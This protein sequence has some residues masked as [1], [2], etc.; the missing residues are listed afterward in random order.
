MIG[1]PRRLPPPTA[2]AVKTTLAIVLAAALAAGCASSGSSNASRDPNAPKRGSRNS[3]TCPARI[4]S[5]FLTHGTV[6]RAC[7]VDTPAHQQPTSVRPDIQP[8]RND[9]C[10]SAEFEFVVGTDGVPEG[11]AVRLVNSNNSAFAEAV[12]RIIP[13]LRY[14][15]ATKGGQ[16]VRQLARFSTI[17]MV[18]V[19][20][21]GARPAPSMGTPHC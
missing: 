16:P 19:T 18:A 20:T 2:C 6:Y 9:R 11:D 3:A 15:P 13:S 17:A 4:D 12:R 7:D 14:S 8:T 5:M 1:G 21:S 10:M